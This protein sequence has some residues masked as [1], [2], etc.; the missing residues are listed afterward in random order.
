MTKFSEPD[1]PMG[2]KK[3]LAWR[4]FLGAAG[5]PRDYI[6]KIA[7]DVGNWYDDDVKRAL[8]NHGWN[9]FGNGDVVHFSYKVNG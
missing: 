3:M 9:W 5:I 4:A 1:N 6:N 8:Q 2:G 7:I